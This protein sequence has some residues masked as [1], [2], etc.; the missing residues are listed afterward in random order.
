MY[1]KLALTQSHVH[2]LAGP[3]PRC[4]AWGYVTHLDNC[5]ISWDDSNHRFVV[6]LTI[7][8]R[9]RSW[10]HCDEEWKRIVRARDIPLVVAKDSACSCG[11]ILTLRD[12]TLKLTDGLIEFHGE[13]VCDNCQ[14]SKNTVLRRIG[15][16]L[17][18]IWNKTK[19]IEVGLKGVTYE[20]ESS[21][22]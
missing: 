9:C 21:E 17:A 7:I 16:G 8:A 4:A 1:D 13:F 2:E 22:K 6:S 20:R 11:S 5:E 19:K 18:S 12:H 15:K 3:C 14:R 10:P